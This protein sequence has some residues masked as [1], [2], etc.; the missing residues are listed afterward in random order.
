MLKSHVNV[1]TFYEVAWGDHGGVE[2]SLVGDDGL[3]WHIH[4]IFTECR[5]KA[6]CWCAGAHLIYLLV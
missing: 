2:D 3:G 6:T 1:L 5:L 4:I